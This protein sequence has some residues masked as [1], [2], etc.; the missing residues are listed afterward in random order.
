MGFVYSESK[1]L[2]LVSIDVI[3]YNSASTVLETLES[4]KRQSYPCI[5][6]II[7][8]DCSQDNT[9][10]VCKKWLK[11]N[12]QKFVNSQ[13]ITSEVN[14]GVVGNANRALQACNG[15]WEKGI[16][17]DDI[18]LPSCI[19]DYVDFI[20]N[21]PEACWVSSYYRA[22]NDY[23]E[24]YNCVGRE[25]VSSRSFFD[26]SV[27]EQLKKMATW[28]RIS[29]PT[30]FVKTEIKKAL[31]YDNQFSFEDYPFMLAMLESGYRCFF[32]EKETICYRIHQ[33]IS[34]SDGQLFNYAFMQKSRRFHKE[35]CYKYLTIWQRA[36]QN[37]VWGMQALLERAGLNRKTRTMDRFYRLFMRCINATFCLN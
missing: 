32:L 25:I 13:I 33:S 28:N 20:L 29:S 19:S 6:L 16:A 17:A 34:H 4:I 3:T 2:P 8:D 35:K 21:N 9:V 23:F 5:E 15:K 31:G 10:D 18:L 24:E 30:L 1:D 26:L 11:D 14:T 12:S 27:K 36:G 37:L 7:S 22:Y